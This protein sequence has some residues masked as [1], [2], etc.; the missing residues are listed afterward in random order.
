MVVSIKITRV[1]DSKIFQFVDSE[2]P[3]AN[4]GL[5]VKRLKLTAKVI[6]RNSHEFSVYPA[7]SKTKLSQIFEV[8]TFG[9]FISFYLAMLYGIDPSEIPW[10]D[11][12]KKRLGQPLGQ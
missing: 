4:W 11:Y 12:F 10:V 1:S 5:N 8:L 3:N 9:S 2:V 7:R 6:E